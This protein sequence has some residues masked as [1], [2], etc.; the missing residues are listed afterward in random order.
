DD[1]HQRS[2]LANH[3]FDLAV[4]EL[5]R[6]IREGAPL[7]QIVTGHAHGGR[8]NPRGGRSLADPV[9]DPFWARIDEA[10][11]RVTTHLGP[12]DYAKYG[13]D[14]SEDPEAVLRDYGALQW[15]LYWGDRPAME[16]VAGM[17]LHGLFSR[18]PRVRVCIAEQGTVWL[19]YLLR[20]MDHAFLMGRKARF[21][22]LDRRP[23][24]I[25]REH[26]IVAPFPEENVK[27]VVAEVG[28]EPIV[29]GSDFPHGE[30]LAFPSQYV[31][32]QLQGMPD[33][34]VKAIMRDNLA[35]FLDLPVP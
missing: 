18:F 14:W 27:R 33:A 28:V 32:A 9:F 10:G 16:T 5:E 3:A 35:R 4:R 25:F 34:E 19:P 30:G 26:F 21:G 11:V 20:K 7:V 8:D 23:S 31:A 13:A 24:Q 22:T 2:A 29:F 12:T 6:V 15:V 17:I 1:L